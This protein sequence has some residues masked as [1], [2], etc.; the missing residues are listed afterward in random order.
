MT[1]DIDV[2]ITKTNFSEGNIKDMLLKIIKIDIKDNAKL[3]LGNISKIREEDEYGGYRATINVK[4]ENIKE[5]FSIDI[6]TGDLITPKA[7]VYNYLPTLSDEYIKLW[8]Y[9]IETVLAKK[10]ET[11]LSRGEASSRTRDYYDI[12]LIYTKDWDNVNKE[13]FRKAVEK[14]FNKREF[15]NDVLESFKVIKSSEIIE[16]RWNNYSKKNKYADNITFEDT[17][18]CLEEMINA[19]ELVMTY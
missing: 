2:A 11:I 9:N 4:I 10:L 8:A 19:L 5:T 6:A 1:M 18:K 17:I 14:T 3:E 12:Y 16:S 15:N 7:I 13:H